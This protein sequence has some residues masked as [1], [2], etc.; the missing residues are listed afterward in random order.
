MAIIFIWLYRGTN[1]DT[2]IFMIY[3]TDMYIPAAFVDL[4]KINIFSI[5]FSFTVAFLVDLGKL[6]HVLIHKCEE[7][8]TLCENIH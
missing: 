7:K 1:E 2:S 4:W 6:F 8:L 3:R 5:I